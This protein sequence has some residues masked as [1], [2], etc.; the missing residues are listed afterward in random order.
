MTANSKQTLQ[1]NVGNEK[2][3]L[4]IM[5]LQELYDLHLVLKKLKNHL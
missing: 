2:K 3:L 5:E 1:V 4:S